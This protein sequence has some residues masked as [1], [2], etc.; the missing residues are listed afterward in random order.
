M[1]DLNVE[2]LVTVVIFYLII[3]VTGIV[4]SRY[5]RLLGQ[6]DSAEMS[7]VAGRNLGLIIG[8]FTMAGAS[9]NFFN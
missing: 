4:A 1:A 2:G 8:V 7:M 9:F 6:D 3:V 5:F